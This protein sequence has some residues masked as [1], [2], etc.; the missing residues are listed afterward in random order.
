M[1]LGKARRIV[2][3]LC[4]LMIVT[5]LSIS[6]A[7]TPR[8]DIK[9]SNDDQTATMDCGG[10]DVTVSGDDNKITLKGVCDKLTVGGDD[11]VIT[12]LQFSEVEVDGDDNVVTVD[13][14]AKITAD[15]DDNTISWKTGPP[16]KAPDISNKGSDNKIVKAGP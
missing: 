15:G 10:K 4:A 6:R 5:Y 3:T 7:A 13:T 9:I 8:Q 11:N 16:G 2:V 14:V 1:N 12:A